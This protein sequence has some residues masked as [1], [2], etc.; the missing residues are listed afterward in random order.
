MR[1]YSIFSVCSVFALSAGA[2]RGADTLPSQF[3]LGRYVPSDAWMYIHAVDNPERQWIEERWEKIGQSL[4]DSGV[5][6][7]IKNL[8]MPMIPA[9]HRD[10]VHAG[11]DRMVALIKGVKWN[12]LARH[13]FVFAERISSGGLSYDY[14]VLMRG[15]RE[16]AKQNFQGLLAIAKEVAGLSDNVGVQE[17]ESG[18]MALVG[19]GARDRQTEKIQPSFWLFKKDDIIGAVMSPP[20]V[21]RNGSM[22]DDVRALLSGKTSTQA[23]VNAPRFRAALSRVERPSDEVSFFDIKSLVSDVRGMF[24][25]VGERIG[26]DNKQA[27]ANIGAMARMMDLVD[28]VDYSI[29]SSSTRSDRF[30]TDQFTLYQTGAKNK[31]L[32]QMCLTASPLSGSSSTY[33]RTRR[34]LV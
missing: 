26:Q 34:V 11:F 31:P 16:S 29:T 23:I 2:A 21:K 15:E 8:V 7:D 3:T 20:V 5:G 30:H 9:E 22:L 14:L 24:H 27:S 13:E 25:I 32:A 1:R 10:E 17:I 19:V 33:R 12:E 6:D 18:G 28:I 4:L